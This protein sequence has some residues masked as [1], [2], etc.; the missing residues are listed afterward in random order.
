MSRSTFSSAGGVVTGTINVDG[1]GSL[2]AGAGGQP[3]TIKGSTTYAFSINPCPDPGGHVS[4]TVAIGDDESITGGGKTVGYQIKD[5]TDYVTSVDDQAEISGLDTQ[6]QWDE[7]IT[8]TDGKDTSEYG[9]GIG[10]T[11]S[12]G[13]GPGGSVSDGGGSTTV[14]SQEGVVTDQAA[15]DM[16]MTMRQ[17]SEPTAQILSQQAA[18]VWKG[19]KCF[20]VRPSP[21]GG[22]VGPGSTTK[23][24]VT[25]HHWVDKADIAVPVTATLSGSKSIDPAGS[26]VESK[27]TFTFTAGQPASTGDV[28]FKSTSKRGIGSTTSSFEVRSA[29]LVDLAGTYKEDLFPISYRLTISAHGIQVVAAPDGTLS[30]SGQAKVKGTVTA[31]GGL[32]RGTI[33]ESIPV[34]GS[35]SLQ[36]PDDA[37]VFHVLDRPGIDQPAGPGAALPADHGAQQPGRLLRPVVEHDRRGRPPGRR[38]HRQAVRVDGLAPTPG[39]R[40]LHR[41]HQVVVRGRP[42]RNP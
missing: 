35:G 10:D 23:V 5:T 15:F 2:S 40:H 25:V 4:G 26:P 16:A 38:R 17:V 30:A 19:G 12:Y 8:T 24:D 33:N 32:C 13:F 36:G 18:Q 9:L 29:L 27:A 7:T 22:D 21:N 34:M 1:G 31:L 42:A 37:Q 11:S 14:S 6:T 39:E 20:E 41:D 28:E 3:A